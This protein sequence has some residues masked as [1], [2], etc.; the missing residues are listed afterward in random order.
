VP[1][2]AISASDLRARVASGLPVRY[3]VPDGV[4]EYIAVQRLYRAPANHPM[5]GDEN[6]RTESEVAG[7]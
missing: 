4:A 6:Q 7:R 2:L 5:A 1:Q 3:L